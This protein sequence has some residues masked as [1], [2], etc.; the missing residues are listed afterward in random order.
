MNQ[1]TAS[2]QYRIMR[3][4]VL[5][6]VVLLGGCA[7]HSTRYYADDVGYGEYDSVYAEPWY[8][9]PASSLSIHVGSVYGYRDPW[10]YPYS[11]LDLFYFGPFAHRSSIGLYSPWAFVPFRHRDPYCCSFGYGH[12]YGH[13]YF[14]SAWP[15]WSP[16]RFYGHSGHRDRYWNHDRRGQERYRPPVD[17]RVRALSHDL[18][19]TPTRR[20]LLGTSRSTQPSPGVTRNPSRAQLISNGSTRSA[21]RGESRNRS[22]VRAPVP[23][24]DRSRML[25]S[26]DS[27]RRSEPRTMPRAADSRRVLSTGS[28]RATQRTVP[29]SLVPAPQNG[30]NR[31]RAIPN[32]APQNREAAGR[33]SN[34]RG[35]VLDRSPATRASSGRSIPRAAPAVSRVQSRAPDPDPVSQSNASSRQAAPPPRQRNNRV[36]AAVRPAAPPPARSPARAVRPA[37]PPPQSSSRDRRREALSGRRDDGRRD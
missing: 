25:S 5:A 36:P 34:T 13:G 3:L 32:R 9:G 35:R 8:G 21:L 12:G 4:A 6:A 22:A 23:A 26:S 20:A 7:T 29:R 33:V 28:S 24:V 37:A 11:S 30:A 27:G 17:A 1:R 10:L 19:G 18:P 14:A 15:R 2:K 31:S 16:A